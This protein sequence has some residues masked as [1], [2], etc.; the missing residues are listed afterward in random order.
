MNPSHSQ[1]KLT[2]QQAVQQLAMAMN[3]GSL[4]PHVAQAKLQQLQQQMQMQMQMQKQQQSQQ[5]QHQ[6]EQPAQQAGT[7][8]AAT[9]LAPLLQQAKQSAQ[10]HVQQ[11]LRSAVHAPPEPAASG[12]VGHGAENGAGARAGAG[13]GI[14]SCVEGAG[15]GVSESLPPL[16]PMLDSL[17]TEDGIYVDDQEFDLAQSRVKRWLELD[18]EIATLSAALRERR[19]Q[20]ED[21]NKHIIS[22]MQGNSVP[23]FEMSRGNLSLQVSKHKQP[24][25][26]KWIM[27]RIQAVEGIS[28]EK[29]QE[30]LRL[31]FEERQVTEKPRLKHLKNRKKK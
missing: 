16:P 15:G 5:P 28:E 31:I 29:Q 23:H 2:H 4:P 12:A 27:S 3:S 8:F 6:Q 9:N 19:K 30:L 25:N 22:F 21:L 14:L 26:Q 11:Q 7:P 20:R 1:Y 10:Q 17:E 13:A 24:L 18:A